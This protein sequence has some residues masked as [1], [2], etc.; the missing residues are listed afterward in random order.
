MRSPSNNG[1]F[2]GL[3]FACQM[4]ENGSLLMNV[5]LGDVS[6]VHLNVCHAFSRF[7]VHTSSNVLNSACVNHLFR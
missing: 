1:R 5:W 2:L 3:L 7:M 6:V 4:A